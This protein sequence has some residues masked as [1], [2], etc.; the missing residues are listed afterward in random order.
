M[1]RTPSKKRSE[2]QQ[3][4]IDYQQSGQSVTNYCTIKNIPPASFNKWRY[5][6][7]RE[8]KPVGL[9]RP[10]NF[11]RIQADTPKPP[12]QNETIHCQLPNGI[13]IEWPANL[14][15]SNLLPLL[16]GLT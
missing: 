11:V 3:I 16:R 13:R 6:F 14:N 1:K 2:W 5:R 12:L 15:A 4:I 7:N 9:D 10:K 8:A